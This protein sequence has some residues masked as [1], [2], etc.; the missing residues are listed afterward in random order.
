MA[1]SRRLRF[2]VLRRDQ[3]TCRYCGGQAP[4]VQLTVDHVV[5]VALGG[6]DDPSNLVAACRDCNAGKASTSPEEHHV[7]GVSAEARRWEAALEQAKR[8]A[9]EDRQAALDEVAPFDARWEGFTRNDNGQKLWRPSNYQESVRTF[10]RSGLP[11]EQMLDLVDVAMNAKVE[12][13]DRFRYF[14]GCCWNAIRK[15][16]ARAEE[17]AAAADGVPPE[18]RGFVDE[19][20]EDYREPD[21]FD[22]AESFQIDGLDP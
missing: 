7:V 8:E 4:D 9:L 17:I 20:Y 21:F 15:I 16:Q 12:H 11:M 22:D 18:E 6:A 10:L 14:C 5:P 1:V 3:H 19:R 13:R 2:E